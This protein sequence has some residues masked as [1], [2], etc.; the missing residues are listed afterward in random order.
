[1]RIPAIDTLERLANV[2]K[3]SPCWLAFGIQEPWSEPAGLRCLSIPARLKGERE[4]QG[5]SLLALGNLSDT[6]DVTVMRIEESRNIPRLD[7]LEKIAAVLKVSPCWLAY[8]R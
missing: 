6:S 4:R 2:L 8:G 5:I 1:M 7:T 3:I